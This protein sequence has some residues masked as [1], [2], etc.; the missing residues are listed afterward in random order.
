MTILSAMPM[1]FR[2]V[3]RRVATGL[4]LSGLVLLAACGQKAPESPPAAD[5][6][7]AAQPA[8]A[9]TVTTTRLESGQ[10]P[11]RLT[12]TGNV[13]PWQEAS[14]SSEVSGVTVSQVLVQVGDR[15]KKGQELARLAPTALDSQQA[16]AQAALA[17]AQ[18]Q[19][20]QASSQVRRLKPLVQENF[21][22][23]SQLDNALA[24]ERSALAAVQSA[25]AALAVAQN[26]SAQRAVVAPDEGS[27][28]ARN[29]APGQVIAAGQELF[30]LIRQNRLEWQAQVPSSDLARVQPGQ[31]VDIRLSEGGVVSGVVRELAPTVD[32]RTRMGLAY[33]RLEQP[34]AT[35]RS[36]QFVQ[37]DIELGQGSGQTLPATALV[38]R[39]GYYHAFV[40]QPD[41]RV[42][43][44]K[45]EVGQTLG[46][47]VQILSGIGPQDAVVATGTGF[48][49]DGDVVR[50][51][52]K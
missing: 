7:S 9:L 35:L 41:Q 20:M 50:V 2:P 26:R 43:D 31:R 33:V 10:W 17:Q 16:Q 14:V 29:I 18:A 40:V 36:G 32:T 52:Q 23:K 1:S 15:V 27:I 48:I 30:R 4:L 49:A 19:A 24:A 22:S 11:M 39:D 8:P 51:V 46:D 42:R 37:G 3:T 12:V 5:A 38:L 6:A 25:Q 28:S 45:V 21:I 44:V 13:L 47:R 34:P